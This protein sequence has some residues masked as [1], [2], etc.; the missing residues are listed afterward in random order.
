M[1]KVDCL[2][3]Y[4]LPKGNPKRRN[5]YRELDQILG[6]SGW[7]R[8]VSSALLVKDLKKAMEIFELVKRYKGRVH[9]YKLLYSVANWEPPPSSDTDNI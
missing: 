1:I 4:D 9:V 7:K 2:V 6:D 5:F 3:T 8:P